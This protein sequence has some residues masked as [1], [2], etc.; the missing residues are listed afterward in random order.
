MTSF[1]SRLPARP[2]RILLLAAA[3]LWSAGSALAQQVPKAGVDPTGGALGSWDAQK[4]TAR[5]LS[6]DLMAAV[7]K[8]AGPTRRW[9]GLVGTSVAREQ[10]ARQGLVRGAHRRVVPAA[11]VEPDRLRRAQGRRR[12]AV[13]DRR[14]ARGLQADGTVARLRERHGL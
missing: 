7:G 10:I 5:G 1:A 4:K 2:A 8:D 9:P 11:A 6:V 12:A 3:A 13:E 14:L